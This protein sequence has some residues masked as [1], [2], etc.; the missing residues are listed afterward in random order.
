MQQYVSGAPME[1]DAIDFTGRLPRTRSG[2]SVI[3]VVGDYLTKWVEALPIPDQTAGTVARTLV[4]QVITRFGTPLEIHTDQGREIEAGLF[5]GVCQLLGIQK[6]QTTPFHPQSDGM[7]ERF[8]RTVTTMLKTRTT[9]M[10]T[11]R[12]S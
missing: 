5:Q 1:C 12:M 6:T 7:V 3:M 11:F 4:E 10:N 2:N 8:N 9:G